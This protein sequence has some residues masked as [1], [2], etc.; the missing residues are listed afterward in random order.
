MMGRGRGF[1]IAG[2]VCEADDDYQTYDRK[3]VLKL[4]LTGFY[5]S[6]KNGADRRPPWRNTTKEKRSNTPATHI[7]IPIL[8]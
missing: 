1:S 3:E 2:R 5:D 8:R 7:L 4:C 6:R